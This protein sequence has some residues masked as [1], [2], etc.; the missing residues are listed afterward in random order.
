MQVK[1]QELPLHEPRGKTGLGL[2]YALASTGA[3]HMEAPHDTDFE[4]EENNKHIDD[5]SL[6]GINEVIDP[7]DLSDKK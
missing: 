6:I 5:L 2:T 1:G 3:D 7:L 4:I